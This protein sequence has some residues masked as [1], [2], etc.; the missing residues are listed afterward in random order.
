[1]THMKTKVLFQAWLSAALLCGCAANQ[2]LA[3]QRNKGIIH[4]YFEEWGN[5]VAPIAPL[6]KIAVDDAFVPLKGELLIGRT[7]AQQRGGQPGLEQ[8]LC[9]H[10]GHLLTLNPQPFSTTKHTN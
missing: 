9:L 4:R 8:N 5:R 3:L 1:M 6:L 7:T 10:V 2:Q